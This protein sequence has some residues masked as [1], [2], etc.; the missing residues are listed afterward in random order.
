MTFFAVSAPQF[1][2]RAPQVIPGPRKFEIRYLL[3]YE[4]DRLKFPS[5]KAGLQDVQ[6]CITTLTLSWATGCR[7]EEENLRQRS[8]IQGPLVLLRSSVDSREI[9]KEKEHPQLTR[10]PRS[11][12]PSVSVAFHDK[13]GPYFIHAEVEARWAWK[14]KWGYSAQSVG[15]PRSPYGILR[16]RSFTSVKPSKFFVGFVP[17]SRITY[18]YMNK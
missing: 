3:K 18:I 11:R 2:L 12:L 6:V 8:A 14:K 15:A 1:A 4:L 7:F 9:W 16:C 5:Q 13:Y 10:A 17:E